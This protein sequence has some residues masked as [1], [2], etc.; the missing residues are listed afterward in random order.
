MDKAQM[1]AVMKERSVCYSPITTHAL[2]GDV[3]VGVYFSQL[4]YYSQMPTSQARGGWFYKVFSEITEETCLSRKEQETA[5]GKLKALGVLECELR[6]PG[7]GRLWFRINEDALAQLIS[8]YLNT[9]ASG[10]DVPLSDAVCAVADTPCAPADMP[11]AV[12]HIS[13]KNSLKT[14]QKK[15][16]SAEQVGEPTSLNSDSKQSITGVG[17]FIDAFTVKT[18]RKPDIPKQYFKKLTDRFNE[19]TPDYLRSLQNF[20]LDGWAEKNGH[21]V[22]TYCGQPIDRWLVDHVPPYEPPPSPFPPPT[23]EEYVALGRNPDGSERQRISNNALLDDVS[24]DEIEEMLS[25]AARNATC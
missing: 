16:S 1:V 23:P 14:S 9:K 22:A 20:F 10:Y 12:A 4:W 3:N 24:L 11:C 8:Q 18:G 15:E 7:A 21:S 2:G 5:R 17:A 25:M 13:S 6:G 19:H